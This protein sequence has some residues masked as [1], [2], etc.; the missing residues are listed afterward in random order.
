MHNGCIQTGGGKACT[1]RSLLDFFTLTDVSG[2]PNI[3]YT[4]GDVSSGTNLYFTKLAAAVSPSPSVP[5]APLAILLPLA[6]LAV[7]GGLWLRARR[8]SP[9]GRRG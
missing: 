2:Q 5:E 6:A 1:D 9:S 3:I 8:A 7:A 4:A